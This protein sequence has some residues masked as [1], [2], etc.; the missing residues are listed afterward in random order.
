TGRGGCWRRVGVDPYR[1]ST[2]IG[3]NRQLQEQQCAQAE[4]RDDFAPQPRHK[5]MLSHV[6]TFGTCKPGVSTTG[7]PVTTSGGP[8]AVLRC[9]SAITFALLRNRAR[10]HWCLCS[11][12]A[13][14]SCDAHAHRTFHSPCTRT[15]SR[16]AVM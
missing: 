8:A 13:T 16:V 10:S 11:T 12:I 7:T 3:G 2:S 5:V 9:N 6:N 1:H 14:R 15:T 4:P